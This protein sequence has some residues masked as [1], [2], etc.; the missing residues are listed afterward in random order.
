[1]NVKPK[2]K[3]NSDKMPI[4]TTSSQ[5]CIKPHV[6]CSCHSSTKIA[7]VEKLNFIIPLVVYPFDVMV[8][9]GQTDDELLKN[10][11]KCLTEEQ[12]R[13]KELWSDNEKDGGTV[14]FASGQTLIRMPK[15][16]KSAKE[17]GTLQHEIF[18]AT[19]F[20]L[21]RIGMILCDKSDEAYAYLIGYL[22]TQIYKR[23]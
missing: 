5:P 16:P 20:V 15:I 7:I 17:Y 12:I 6:V 3:H 18:H 19:E 2:Q 14:I 21:S 22:T 13:N 10:L 4:D 9:F 11:L 8:S 23:I 1:M